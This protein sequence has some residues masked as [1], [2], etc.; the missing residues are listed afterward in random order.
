MKL[1]TVKLCIVTKRMVKKNFKIAPIGIDVTNY[2]N[3]FKKLCKKWLKY[4]FS[5]INYVTARK[6]IFKILLWLLKVKI[7]EFEY[8]C[9]WF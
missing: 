9:S 2:V 8:I 1:G 7:T 5:K 3:C 6:K 4:V